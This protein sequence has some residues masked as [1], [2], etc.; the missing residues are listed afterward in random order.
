MNS[1]AEQI[2]W[3]LRKNFWK[4]NHFQTHAH[5]LNKWRTKLLP[6]LVFTLKAPLPHHGQPV[7][8]R[9][10]ERERDTERER[11]K[12]RER[13]SQLFY[14]SRPQHVLDYIWGV[15][16]SFSFSP[17]LS[18]GGQPWGLSPANSE[19]RLPKVK[20]SRKLSR[21]SLHSSFKQHII[22][23]RSKTLLF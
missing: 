10:R 17:F 23:L 8:D 1:L 15:L 13:R 14:G 7:V 11:E 22:Q 21:T 18:G 19:V 3:P 2:H 16:D 6:I 9:E 12:E 4:R 5:Y 20:P